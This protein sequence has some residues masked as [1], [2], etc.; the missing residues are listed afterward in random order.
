MNGAMRQLSAVAGEGQPSLDVVRTRIERRLARAQATSELTGVTIDSSM[1]AVERAQQQA[2][3]HAR[4]DA[5]REHLGLPA[6]DPTGSEIR[7]SRIAPASLA[8]GAGSEPAA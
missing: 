7:V 3:A 5:M 2:L 8:S 4:L 6:P 1:V